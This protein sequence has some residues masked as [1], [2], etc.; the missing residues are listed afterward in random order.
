MRLLK[1]S[2]TESAKRDF[3]LQ[4]VSSHL[5]YISELG[6]R[7]KFGLRVGYDSMPWG[8]AFIDACARDAGLPNFPSFVNTSAGLAEALRRGH[9][10][11]VPEPGDIV[12]FNFS[13]M[14]GPTAG[15]FNQPHCGVVTDTREFADTG[16]FISVEGGIEGSTVSSKKDGV[17][18]KIR[19]M[20]D[21][22]LFY[23]P[24][25]Q[26][27]VTFNERL[28][29]IFD[30]ARTRFSKEETDAIEEFA[31]VPLILK[32]NGE[33][34]Y[35]M[36]NKRVEIIQLALAMVTDLRGAE[37]GKWDAATAAACSRF[38]RNIGR[39]GKDVTGLPDSST[40]KRLSQDTKVFIIEG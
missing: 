36:R 10:Y 17:H 4:T 22:M 32:L 14:S 5:G 38:Q 11:R 2:E 13:S 31:R 27:L 7:N 30:K 40:L 35:G 9:D 12:I 34:R 6:G 18:Q 23:R 15:A 33:I 26:E 21:V 28:M 1:S 8:G 25:F 24:E 29:Q 16:R 3:F 37:S 20:T 19:H 39:T